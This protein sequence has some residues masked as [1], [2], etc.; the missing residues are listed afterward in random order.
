MRWEL[1]IC[2]APTASIAWPPSVALCGVPWKAVLFCSLWSPNT[3]R[4]LW[5]RLSL[6]RS[7][8]ILTH[9]ISVLFASLGLASLEMT[10][11]L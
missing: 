10:L 3:T 4:L 2:W 1:G 9:A 8:I 6:R 11:F 5:P 7:E